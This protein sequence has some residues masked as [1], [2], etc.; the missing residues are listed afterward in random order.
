MLRVMEGRSIQKA[1]GPKTV[2]SQVEGG[3]FYFICIIVIKRGQ[4]C[5]YQPEIH[6]LRVLINQFLQREISSLFL[7]PNARTVYTGSS[8]SSI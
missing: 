4:L 5:N 8:F 6:M 2:K 1:Q 7:F 3:L